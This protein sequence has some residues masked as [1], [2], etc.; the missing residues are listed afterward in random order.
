MSN[1]YVGKRAT[2]DFLNKNAPVGTIVFENDGYDSVSFERGEKYWS[3]NEYFF[4]CVEINHNENLFHLED[5]YTI[6]RWGETQM[7]EWVEEE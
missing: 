2:A 6:I 7:P 5:G 1:K 3:F 4:D